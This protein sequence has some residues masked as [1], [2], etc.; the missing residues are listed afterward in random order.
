VVE[1]RR[2]DAG[3]TQL[4]ESVVA[5]RNLAR[6]L[7]TPWRPPELPQN[8]ASWLKSGW[9]GDAPVAYVGLD[10]QRVVASGEVTLPTYDNLHLADIGV[11]VTPE[12]RRRGFGSKMLEALTSTSRAAGRTV[13]GG[14]GF[15]SA[16]TRGFA[17]SHRFEPK[18]VEVNRRQT[19]A[20]ADWDIIEHEHAKA[21]DVAADYRLIRVSGATPKKLLPAV[22]EM[23]AA[24][25]DAPNDDLDMEP[26]IFTPERVTKYEESVLATQRL[27]RVIAQHRKTGVMAG[28]TVVTVERD[29][30]GVGEQ[31]DTSVVRGHRGHRLGVLLKAEMLLWLR[32]QE[33]SLATIDTW[34]A[35]SNVHMIAVNE[36]L[37]YQVMGE[38][39]YYQAAL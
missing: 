23:T 3:D 12:V 15:D 22:A 34:N 4:V 6:L 17:A 9:D 38:S 31:D 21:R 13:G 1:I 35:K 29:R 24:I 39:T 2:Y 33:P 14:G 16:A 30:P 11:R 27:Y 18:I 32:E 19:L 26:E 37:G 7:D 20:D 36:L 5:H 28:H 25:N 10:G 8:W